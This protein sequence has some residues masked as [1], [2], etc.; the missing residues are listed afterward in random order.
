MRKK[1]KMERNGVKWG[2][3]DVI[4]R[5]AQGGDYA[6]D[7]ACDG[8]HRTS[9]GV[10]PTNLFGGVVAG[11]EGTDG[12]FA[13]V[14]GPDESSGV[15]ATA[16]TAS[17]GCTMISSGGGKW[18]SGASTGGGQKK[19]SKAFA[20]PLR[21][22][23]KSPSNAGDEG[24]DGYSFGN[25]MY[26]MMM[27]NQMDNKRREQQH[28]SNSEQ[29]GCEYQLHWE[30]MAIAHKEACDQRQMMNLMFMQMLSRPGGRTAT[31]H[32]VPAPRTLRIKVY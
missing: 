2:A 7:T 4:L 27:Q 5:A 16:S 17:T 28:K 12:L 9:L 13:T 31:C 23:R 32:L 21:I 26:M 8:G 22:V 3:N 25:M 15:A 29:R 14:D 24:E 30:E 19:K 18:S 11:V 6:G 20:Q 10:D 1:V